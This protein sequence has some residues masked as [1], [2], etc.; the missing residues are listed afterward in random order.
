MTGLNRAIPLESI[1][2]L[3]AERQRQMLS[4]VK[5]KFLLAVLLCFAGL[6]SNAAPDASEK[7]IGMYIHQHWPYHHPYAARTWTLEDWRGYAG[8]LK[9]LGYNTLL[10]WP[11]LETM[12][13]PLTRSDKANLKKIARVIDML[14]NEFGM[15]A[16]IVLCPNVIADNAA[17][18]KQPF[19]KRHF[20]YCDRR[21]DPGDPG[22]MKNML[23]WRAKLLTPLS[24]MDGLVIIDSDPGGYPDS[25]NEEF[26]NLLMAHRAVLDRLRPG[27]ELIY[28]MNAGWRAYGRFYKTGDM[29]APAT[30]AEQMDVL[31][32]LKERDPAPWGLA[33]GLTYARK[34]GMADKVISFN[35]GRIE[36]EP[37]F[38]MS[39]FGGTSAYD[40][41][42]APGPRGVI[43]NAQTHC[44]QL[45]NTFAFVRGA[46]GKPVTETDYV[47]F[48][49]D[50]IPG[51]G[52]TIVRAWETLAGSD[53]AAMR[54]C[55][56]ELETIPESRLKPGPLRGLLFGS[57]RRFMTDLAMMLRV[58]AGF[59]ALQTAT[60]QNGNIKAALDEFVAATEAWQHRHGYENSMNWGGL[61]ETLRK[62]NSPEVNAVLDQRFNPFVPAKLLPGETPFACVARELRDTESETPRLLKALEAARHE[63][64]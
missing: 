5:M 40:G 20:F 13:D 33:N 28:W 21:V 51:Q 14:H 30:D 18:A 45:A 64:K 10:I 47:R 15:R 9:R 60:S 62:L 53:A 48:A 27:I 44:I 16:Y 58:R 32:Q 12:P 55:A 39:N 50:L 38:P 49:E 36:G 26:V 43:G 46:L 61:D 57:P 22:A 24:K 56:V 54:T 41:G 2:R 7:I 35:Y 6:F 17:A 23:D 63:V 34:L 4:G 1:R 52:A 25:S 31:T 11:V 59:L 29:L 37:S 19:P 3:T 42:A 8:G